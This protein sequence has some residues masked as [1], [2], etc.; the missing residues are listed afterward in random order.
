MY[1][2]FCG[3]T[4]A[5]SMPARSQKRSLKS[6]SASLWSPVTINEPRCIKSSRTCPRWH[7]FATHVDA[8]GTVQSTVFH[9]SF[10]GIM[11]EAERVFMTGG[12]TIQYQ[13]VMSF[14]NNGASVY[15]GSQFGGGYNQL[16]VCHGM[17]PCTATGRHSIN[18]AAKDTVFD[19]DNCEYFSTDNLWD[20]YSAYK[21]AEMYI[22]N[23]GGFFPRLDMGSRGVASSG[24]NKAVWYRNLPNSA[25]CGHK[26]GTNRCQTGAWLSHTDRNGNTTSGPDLSSFCVNTGKMGTG[27]SYQYRNVIG[28]GS[29]GSTNDS[30]NQNSGVGNGAESDGGPSS[31]DNI[32]DCNGADVD[33]E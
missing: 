13:D 21:L 8:S 22:S 19:D 26:D 7:Y 28:S 9:W 30:C 16:M 20:Y 23:Q 10:N 11:N 4:V 32:E 27:S 1:F 25:V 3:C 33:T 6:T 18:D 5:C 2:F 31:L 24:G 14:T 29:L 12:K 17:A 15:V